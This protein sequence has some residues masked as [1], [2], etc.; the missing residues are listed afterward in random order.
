MEILVIKGGN[1]LSGEIQ[2]SGAKN[3]AMK[4]I[5]ASLLTDEELKIKNVPSI[6]SVNGTVNMLKSFGI[7]IKSDVAHEIT[8]RSNGTNNH[9]IPLEYGG[10]YRSATMMIG[11]LL[12]RFGKAMVPNPGG[13]RIGKRPIDRHIE[14]L[15]AM[16]AD[17]RYEQGYFYATGRL[18]GN[19]YRFE[20]NSHTGT[21]ALILAGV[22]ATG[23]TIIENAAEEPEVDDLINLLNLMGSHIV[24]KKKRT[25]II[26]GVKKLSG[27]EFTIMPDRNEVVTFAIAAIA[28][29]GDLII[30]G[31]QKQYLQSFLENLSA[32]GGG[33]EV[34][35]TNTIRF[36]HN[37]KMK[38]TDIVTSAHPGFMTDWQ[39]PWSLLMTQ[40]EG[41]STV[42]ETVYEDRFGYVRQLQKMG[43]RI[44]FYNPPVKNLQTTYNF[45]WSKDDDCIGHAIK[46]Y[47]PAK[48]H[49]AILEV[50]DLR[51]GA[52]LL[53]SA[54]IAKGTSVLQGIEHIDRGYEKIEARLRQI[55]ADIKRVNQ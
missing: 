43:A 39:A 7:R 24:R 16:G 4:V 19:T 1:K 13:C 47:G 48:L 36:F 33:W 20:R 51:A 32:A 6:S 31:A 29:G 21:E 12:Y 40:A 52:T 25:I 18:K 37:G 41:R 46:I 22:C 42:H 35:D 53:I 14:G 10:L 9:I 49:N 30:K 17:I 26:K 2:V 50:S 34:M 45:N 23:E 55:G 54:L 11:P 27:A 15:R 44:D 38:A 8:L 28:S 5:L 3:A